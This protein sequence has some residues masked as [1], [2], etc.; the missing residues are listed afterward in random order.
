MI[1]ASDNQPLI[2]VN[3]AVLLCID[4]YP[5]V[6]VNLYHICYIPLIPGL[7]L[8]FVRVIG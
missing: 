2:F 5:K 1:L 4:S 7:L 6:K 8:V 3:R